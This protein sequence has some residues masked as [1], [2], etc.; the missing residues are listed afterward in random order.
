MLVRV[1]KYGFWTGFLDWGKVLQSIKWGGRDFWEWMF[2]GFRRFVRERETD[3]DAGVLS[4]LERGV[5]ERWDWWRV[6]GKWR[7]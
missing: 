4:G 2:I 5:Q 6:G 1:L 7:D 3:V